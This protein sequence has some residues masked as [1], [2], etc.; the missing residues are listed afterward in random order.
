L[1][2]LFA[3]ASVFFFRRGFVRNG[4]TFLTAGI[5]SASL[6]V[7]MLVYAAAALFFLSSIN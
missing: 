2:L 3:A 5:A 4:R 1:F 6:A 7:A